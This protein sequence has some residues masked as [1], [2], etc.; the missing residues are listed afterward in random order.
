[1]S[2]VAAT[3]GTYARIALRRRWQILVPLVLCTAGAA[4]SLRYLPK[5]YKA[6]TVI[7]VQPQHIP[8]DYVK[9]TVTTSIE[10]GLKTIQQ[11]ITS[12]TRLEQVARDLGLFPATDDPR[13]QERQIQGMRARIDLE[14]KQDKS[15]TLSYRS[16]DPVLAAK[17]A[18]RLADVFIDENARGRQQQAKATSVFLG[19][20]LE[21]MRQDLVAK[22]AAIA[23]FKQ[24]HQEE[25]P[26]Q[27]D[28]NLRALESTQREVRDTEMQIERARDRKAFLE[29]QAAELAPVAAGPAADPSDP[30]VQLVRARQDLAELR[31]RFTDR[32]PEV[33]RLQERV[34][35]L[36]AQ[37]AALPEPEAGT[38]G[39]P[40]ADRLRQEIRAAEVEISHLESEAARLREDVAVYRGRSENAPRREQELLSLTRDYDTLRQNYQALLNK[41]QEARLAE[42]LESERQG[43]QFVVLDRARPPAIPFRPDPVQVIGIGL[44]LGLA[45]GIGWV[46]LS[47]ALSPTFYAPQQIR[48]ALAVT[49]LAAVP[50]I[51]P[52]KGKGRSAACWGALLLGLAAMLGIG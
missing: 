50:V 17:A 3:L 36:E 12:R 8:S 37:V 31:A 20:E 5:V 29:A 46:T 2:D 23:A 28:A 27:Q 4:T 18:N 24:Q 44:L 10:G 21:R 38:T 48:D 35:E 40:A 45:L 25:M 19:D 6:T 43:E 14:V 16:E 30:R 15:F 1:M 26:T 42:T 7:L 34:R 22:E 13:A 9:P 47:E 52:P 39:N 33:Q 11:Q 49:V 41:K 51:R 32:Y